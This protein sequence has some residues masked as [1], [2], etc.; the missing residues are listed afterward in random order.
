MARRRRTLW[1][2]VVCLA[3]TDGHDPV[4]FVHPRARIVLASPA[5]VDIPVQ[6]YVTPHP[7]NRS[8][9]I[10]WD[11]EACGGSSSGELDGEYARALYPLEP[12]KV[13]LYQ[14]ECLFVAV[15]YGA[16]GKLR[17]RRELPV[18]VCGGGDTPCGS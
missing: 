5:G 14:G 4:R 9:T 18:K 13:R 7:D 16:A 8:V 12:L 2:A 17:A 15:V 3:L 1:L 11:G 10:A 6:T